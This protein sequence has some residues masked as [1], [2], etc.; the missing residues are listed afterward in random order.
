MGFWLL[1]RVGSWVF[2]YVPEEGA[3]ATLSCVQ[4]RGAEPPQNSRFQSGNMKQAAYWEPTN[5]RWHLSKICRLGDNVP[6][7]FASSCTVPKIHVCTTT[8]KVLGFSQFAKKTSTSMFCYPANSS[9]KSLGN[10]ANRLWRSILPWERGPIYRFSHPW[11]PYTVCRQGHGKCLLTSSESFLNN[12]SMALKTL[13]LKHSRAESSFPWTQSLLICS[14]AD[15]NFQETLVL[16][17]CATVRDAK[18]IT[19]Q[20]LRRRAIFG[21]HCPSRWRLD[22]ICFTVWLGRVSVR[23]CDCN[24]SLGRIYTSVLE[25]LFPF[26]PVW[27]TLF[28]ILSALRPYWWNVNHVTILGQR[29]DCMRLSSKACCSVKRH[30]GTF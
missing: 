23:D 7:S 14:M 6:G 28:N 5:F 8:N 21:R 27:G 24:K 30:F 26:T 2:S 4:S 1:Q 25:A 19:H 11:E 3:D 15:S 17:G 12:S 10:V 9:S 22:L 16:V 13:Y 18:I 20:A 29:R